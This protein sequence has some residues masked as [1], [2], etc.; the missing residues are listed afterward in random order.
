MGLL[1]GEPLGWA[2]PTVSLR[3]LVSA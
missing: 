2:R 3:S 1:R